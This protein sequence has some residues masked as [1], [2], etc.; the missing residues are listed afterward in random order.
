MYNF[1][2]ININYISS[3]MLLKIFLLLFIIYF[4]KKFL[5]NKIFFLNEKNIDNLSDLKYF[6][7]LYTMLLMLPHLIYFFN[8][9][10]TNL[11]FIF[12]SFNLL[13]SLTLIIFYVIVDPFKFTLVLS[14]LNPNKSWS[15]NIIDQFIQ[16]STF[17][18]RYIL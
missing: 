1:T 4:F 12:S 5:K 10:K 15:K 17:S 11:F 14:G 8:F 3:I 9:Y 2:F 18:M 16:F 6:I 7:K 13:V